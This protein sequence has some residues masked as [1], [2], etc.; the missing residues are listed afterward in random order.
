[1]TPEEINQAEREISISIEEAK[2]FLERKS[3]LARLE[4]N[5][6]FRK[7]ILELYLEKEPARLVSLLADPEMDEKDI[8]NIKRDMMGISTFK[9]FL[10]NTYRLARQFESMIERSEK[11]LENL[12]AEEE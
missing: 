4:R 3:M 12:R 7:L 10:V 5:E 2:V 1:M 11:E 9:H 8:E 6:D